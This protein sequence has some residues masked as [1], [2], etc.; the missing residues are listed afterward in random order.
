MGRALMVAQDR[1]DSDVPFFTAKMITARFYAES[2]LT[3]AP[4]LA[5]SIRAAG[6]T[7]NRMPVELF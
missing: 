6:A 7:T 4:G 5:H 3:Q 1:M 2:I